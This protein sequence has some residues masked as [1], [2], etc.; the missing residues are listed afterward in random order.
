MADGAP[1]PGPALIRRRALVSGRVQGV[2]FR[3]Q[4]RRLALQHG[5]AGTVRNLA[6]GRVEI[7]AEGSPAAVDELLAWAAE[8]PPRARVDDVT[9]VEEEPTGLSGFD[10]GW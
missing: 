8:G 6:D 10:V 5:V 7:V 2:F 9:T 1:Q 4:T 3:D